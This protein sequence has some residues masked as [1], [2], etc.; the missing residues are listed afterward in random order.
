[1]TFSGLPSVRDPKQSLKN[2][3]SSTSSTSSTSS[4]GSSSSSASSPKSPTTSRN[5]DPSTSPQLTQTH[6][7]PVVVAT[8]SMMNR[9]SVEKSFEEL[10]QSS[11]MDRPEL[12]MPQISSSFL[13]TTSPTYQELQIQQQQQMPAP[14][15][16]STPTPLAPMT[17]KK[18]SANTLDPTQHAAYRKRLNVNQVCDW[19]RYRK[20]RCD[21]ES[22]CNSCI[23]SKRECI[24]SPP[25]ALINTL[26]EPESS[27]KKTKRNREDKDS[28]RSKSYRGSSTS[29]QRSSSYNSY[30]SPGTDDEGSEASGARSSLSP[31]VGSLTLA[32]LGL[33]SLG[34][35]LL[36]TRRNS[37]FSLNTPPFALGNALQDQEHLD[38]VRRIEML[39]CNVIPGAAEFI[40]NG[41]QPPA[42]TP[43]NT[44]G[45]QPLS[46]ITQ[47]LETS[48]F[49]DLLSPQER[50]ANISL[51]SPSVTLSNRPSWLSTSLPTLPEEG[52]S[53][54]P[55]QQQ[56]SAFDHIERMKRIELLL[57]SISDMP[58]AKALL[59][60]SQGSLQGDQ[61]NSDDKK[62]SKKDSKKSNK[63]DA[64]KNSNGNVVKRP[65]VAAGFAGQKPPPKLPQAL[66]EAAN[67]KQAIR[68]KRVSAAAAARAAAKA[69]AGTSETNSDHSLMVSSPGTVASPNSE[70]F[71]V[72]S[73]TFASLD[74]P[75][76][77]DNA[78]AMSFAQQDH[79]QDMFIQQQHR[80]QMD[81]HRG[82]ISF[83][84]NQPFSQS[85]TYQL[86]MSNVNSMT[87][88]LSD[89]ISSYGSLVVPASSSTCSSSQSSPT[90]AQAE[91]IEQG[92]QDENMSTDD[93]AGP[94]EMVYPQQGHLQMAYGQST[95]QYQQQQQHNNLQSGNN[96][97]EYDMG[98]DLMSQV[99]TNAPQQS[100]LGIEAQIHPF[101]QGTSAHHHQQ[102]QHRQSIQIGEGGF[103]DFGLNMNESLE[104]LMKKNMGSLN[105]LVSSLP[106][107]AHALHPQVSQS[108]HPSQLHGGSVSA[109]S[110]MPI[111]Q[112]TPGYE[113]MYG[114]SGQ[115]GYFQQGQSNSSMIQTGISQPQQQT[116]TPSEAPRPMWFPNQSGSFSVPASTPEFSW[117]SQQQQSSQSINISANDSPEVELES[118]DLNMENSN[119]QAQDHPSTLQHNQLKQQ[120]LNAHALFQQQHVQQ[121]QR[122]MEQQALQQ[123]QQQMQMHQQQKQLHRASIQH[124]HQQTFY[125]PQMQDDDEEPEFGPVSAVGDSK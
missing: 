85:H 11:F 65:H 78:Q 50:L 6:G 115:F 73:N 106:N 27:S 55:S 75:S 76:S 54:S 107:D 68:K 80:L 56:P 63:R 7:H 48:S 82:S 10:V 79:H 109:A 108:H 12:G 60:H 44:K 118:L 113:T 29:S 61:K 103:S 17:K 94:N 93:G 86:T 91:A 43:S 37:D 66:A 102:H 36:D 34:L 4:N 25:S 13:P 38:R 97:S 67:K 72:E 18:G 3:S 69:A 100:I 33:S 15:H 88:P 59:T 35:D 74:I 77:L 39:L 98:F 47:G 49:K 19:C 14:A 51:K 32:G 81:Q 64:K 58:L 1:M 117:P 28:R 116:F 40:A 114:A 62:G 9:H 16:V 105:G 2:S 124:Q 87:I 26:S 53:E 99:L 119:N 70:A 83:P 121:Q 122:H 57:S 31:V 104:S 71:S 42:I 23:H 20:I 120:Q 90:L 21:R 111:L 46:L 8:E 110:S 84:A 41:T 52:P 123:Q 95:S 92:H 89:P 125:I 112:G 24:R 30:S 5:A 101:T 22:P 45:D 96:A